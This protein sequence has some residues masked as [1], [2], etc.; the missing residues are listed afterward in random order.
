[1]IVTAGSSAIE[2]RVDQGEADCLLIYQ[3]RWRLYVMASVLVS[4]S[5]LAGPGCGSGVALMGTAD[6]Q[7]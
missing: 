3:R 2:L 4:F 6:A 1:M 7:A 5:T